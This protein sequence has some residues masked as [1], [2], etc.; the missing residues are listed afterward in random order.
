M[1]NHKLNRKT[2]ALTL[3]CL[4]ALTVC[5]Q[6]NAIEAAT[7]TSGNALP[8][9]EIFEDNGIDA[10]S[11]FHDGLEEIYDDEDEEDEAVEDAVAFLNAM[12]REFG[13]MID[14]DDMES[15]SLLQILLIKTAEVADGDDS[16][17][18]DSIAC[19]VDRIIKEAIKRT[20]S[21]VL[22]RYDWQE[23]QESRKNVRFVAETLSQEIVKGLQK[24]FAD[25][26]QNK[27][28]LG[29][30]DYNAAFLKGA[31]IG[32]FSLD[33]SDD[34]KAPTRK[35]SMIEHEMIIMT[36]TLLLIADGADDDDIDV[37][38]QSLV[39]SLL[40]Q[41][42]RSGASDIVNGIK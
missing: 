28:R 4:C 12:K 16:S 31:C 24:N 34:L 37:E 5:C 8:A 38:D 30:S 21:R 39:S 9:D 29:D 6:F 11:I 26:A 17:L 22:L 10:V 35:V 15:V 19:A 18:S 7:L 1:T 33:S 20:V 40:D 14:S 32:L 3:I 2:V 27:P 25:Y 13:K 36:L 42:V 23:L 41:V